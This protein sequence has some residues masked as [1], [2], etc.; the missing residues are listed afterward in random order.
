MGDELENALQSLFKAYDLDES[1]ELSRNE[2][3]A[4]E[5]RLSFETG[6]VY[7]A[8]SG[9][10][11]MTLADRDGSGFLDYEEFRVRFL[12]SY[13][14]QGMGRQ[15]IID[16]ISKQ[17]KMALTERAK[18]GPRYHAGIRQ[19]LRHIFDL[20]DVSGDGSLSPEE[21][22]AAQK[23]VA[24]EVSDDLDEGWVDEAAF[25]AADEN[26]DG[27][28]DLGE[29]ME[30]SFC[31]FEGVKKRTDVILATLQRVASVL[32][33][34]Q[35]SENKST[36]PV[37]VYVQTAATPEF[38]APHAAWQDAST[39]DA[40]DK[41]WQ[42]WKPVGELS[43]PLN[44][45][46]AEDV[47]S[48]LRLMLKLP[49]E[50]WLSIYYCGPAREGGLRPVTL[51][52]GD[53][54]GEGNTQAMLQYLSKPNAE[55]KLYVKNQ[56]KRPSKLVRQPR[57]FD[58]ERDALL[59]KRTGQ[60]W[61]LDWETQLVGE[62][63]PLPPRPTLLS[64]GD[65]L[66]IEASPP[67]LVQMAFSKQDTQLPDGLWSA[68]QLNFLAVSRAYSHLHGPQRCAQQA[69]PRAHRAE[70]EQEEEEGGCGAGCAAAAYLC[71]REGGQGRVVCGHELGGPGGENGLHATAHDAVA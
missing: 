43:L 1:G 27:V 15:D 58:D 64:L 28:L 2:F 51:L 47:A 7:K 24:M 41:N 29:F 68:L 6:E 5:M 55:L 67:H 10:A 19:V 25:A 34:E 21:W 59:A 40:P 56:R 70:E 69:V 30:A 48:L 54:P 60:C 14:E 18:M 53:R 12:T 61:G 50:T 17:V 71:R 36:L 44:L 66:I 49:T 45:A 4:I 3:L 46:T 52:R 13:Q 9:S 23:T 20:F 57:V 33:K 42:A 16:H 26:G 22:I 11:K 65:A 8:D 35:S 37:T 39:E 32:E 62:G 31:M 63:H 38:Q